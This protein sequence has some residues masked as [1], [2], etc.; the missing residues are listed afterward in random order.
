VTKIGDFRVDFLRE[1]EAIFKKALTRVSGAHRGSCL[2]IKNHRSCF[3]TLSHNVKIFG[4]A[5]Y[6]AHQMYTARSYSSL[7][8]QSRREWVEQNYS[9]SPYPPMSGESIQYRI[10]PPF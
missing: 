9:A 6:S 7:L 5:G 10:V 3:T 2:M 1:F 8:L 4:L